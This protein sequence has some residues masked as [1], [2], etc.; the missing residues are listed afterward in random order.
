MERGETFLDV[1]MRSRARVAELGQ[2][3]IRD[4]TVVMTHG[5]SLVVE[6]ALLRAARSKHFS[7]VVT[8]GRATGSG[9]LVA[10]KM[11]AAGI[12]CTIVLDAAMGYV[13]ERVDMVIVGAEGVVENG[14]IISTVGTYQLAIT[15]SALKTPV[16]VAAESY[17][18][19]RLFPLSQAEVQERLRSKLEAT[20]VGLKSLPESA[21]F[22]SPSCDYTPPQYL[23][24]LFTDLGILTPSA[25]SDELIKLYA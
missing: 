15:A 1:S 11:A 17:K 6:K 25:V 16:Y 19:T 13:M 23:T 3:F 9:A 7:V 4:G 8:E 14:G 12:P 2:S 5:H 10:A 24:L 20:D 22:D 21:T 18:F